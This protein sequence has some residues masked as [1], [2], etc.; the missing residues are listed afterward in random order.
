MPYYN[1]T[2]NIL[3]EWKGEGVAALGIKNCFP[4][5]P[6]RIVKICD[7]LKNHLKMDKNLCLELKTLVWSVTE[8]GLFPSVVWFL[9]SFG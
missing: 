7:Q 2:G 9:G 4:S 1:T 8:L 3:R 6:L 5:N